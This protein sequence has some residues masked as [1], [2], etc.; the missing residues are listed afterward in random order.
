MVNTLK[1][2]NHD[3]RTDS[4]R[5]EWEKSRRIV[6]FNLRDDKPTTAQNVVTIVKNMCDEFSFP[7]IVEYSK[8]EG[9]DEVSGI[10]QSCTN[11]RKIDDELMV[12]K[13]NEIR[14]RDN[15]FEYG[16]LILIDSDL[17]SFAGK[18]KIW[19]GGHDDGLVVIKKNTEDVIRHELG[20]MFGLWVHCEK[21][22]V[23]RYECGT[24]T[25]CEQ[26]KNKIKEHL[27]EEDTNVRNSCI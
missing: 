5:F 14:R 24:N 4:K 10:L 26:C 19:G 22:C 15:K 27:G 8:N 20:H 21:E 12:K 17:Y 25:F 6:I 23:M 16:V 3:W 9:D 11:K 1:M 2:K 18:D 7:F 13:L